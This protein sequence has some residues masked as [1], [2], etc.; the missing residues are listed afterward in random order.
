MGGRLVE[1]H[2]W[3]G[4]RALGG[5]AHGDQQTLLGVSGNVRLA[6]GADALGLLAE[7]AEPGAAPRARDQMCL[8]LTGALRR[9]LAVEIAAQREE[10]APHSAIS[11]KIE[12]NSR[13]AAATKRAVDSGEHSSTRDIS[14]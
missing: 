13:R 8:E 12:P 14:R 9:Q 5:K 7:I 6:E 4:R 10:A 1:H 2:R 11:R 3:P